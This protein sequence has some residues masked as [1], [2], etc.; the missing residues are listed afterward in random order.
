[1]K[2]A[3]VA[4]SVFVALAVASACGTKG[5][6]PAS[7]PAPTTTTTSVPAAAPT[8]VSQFK[9]RWMTVT[10]PASWTES[11]RRITS[12]FQQFGLRP[13]GENEVPR[14]CN[15]CGVEP[16]TAYLTAYA[17]GAFD[18]GQ[19]RTGEA[20]TVN[21]DNDGF[22]RASQNS[23]DAVLAWQYADNA[24]ATVRGRTTM[25]SERDRMVELARALRPTQFTEIHLPLSIPDAPASP[26][27]AE[28]NIDRGVYGTT[29]SFAQCGG[30]DIGGTPACAVDSP[31]LRVHIWPAADYSGLIDEKKAT[32]IQIGGRDGLY[33]ESSGTAAVKVEPGMVVVFEVPEA[34][35][36]KILSTVVWAPDPGNEKTWA[37]VSDWVKVS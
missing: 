26:P 15:G 8:T 17:A 18:P 34:E 12:E 30:T 22:Y 36:R 7:S 13:V 4:V 37:A 6:S 9:P 29:L 23:D 28:I 16:P 31:G 14:G 21:A 25:T 20:V 27:L 2:L 11:D 3:R 1:M 10:A 19:A 5:P 32:P 24:W 35:A 33:E